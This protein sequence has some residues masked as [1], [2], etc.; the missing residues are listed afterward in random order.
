MLAEIKKVKNLVE[1][2][3]MTR[4]ETRRSDL[5]LWFAVCDKF[6]VRLTEEQKNKIR[7][8]NIKPETIRR[9]RQKFQQMGLYRPPEI[10]RQARLLEA[11]KMK[12][13]H[14]AF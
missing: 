4:P 2:I 12:S 13:I 3:L 8:A 1:S 11:K 6:D 14:S 9:T 7:K 5:E 10:I